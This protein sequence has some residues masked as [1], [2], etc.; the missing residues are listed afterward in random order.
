MRE[1][2]VQGFKI[3]EPN[4]VKKEIKSELKKKKIRKLKESGTTQKIIDN[5][6]IA[7]ADTDFEQ[8]PG[9]GAYNPI[10]F[11]DILADKKVSIPKSKRFKNLEKDKKKGL[12]INY[13]HVE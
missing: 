3:K 9:P 1:K 7:T 11:D 2:R 12:S 8:V 10:K 6:S 4:L 13:T 5:I